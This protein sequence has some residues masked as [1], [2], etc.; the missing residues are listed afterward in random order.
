MLIC[1]ANPPPTHTPKSVDYAVFCNMWTVESA[2]QGGGAA[3]QAGGRAFPGGG[4]FEDEGAASGL[5]EGATTERESAEGPPAE[6]RLLTQPQV[7]SKSRK[8]GDILLGR[9]GVLQE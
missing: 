1:L 4:C 6:H 3:E 8:A 2:F 9:R 5:A 7:K